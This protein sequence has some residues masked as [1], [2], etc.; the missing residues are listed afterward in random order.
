[1]V[2]M[3]QNYN[4]FKYDKTLQIFVKYFDMCQYTEKTPLVPENKKYI[5]CIHV[6][7]SMVI[8]TI[9]IYL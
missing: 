9:Y 1:M 2:F 4:L 8:A 6:Y 5:K 3:W 7:K